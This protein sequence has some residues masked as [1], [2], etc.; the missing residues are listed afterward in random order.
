MEHKTLDPDRTSIHP[1]PPAYGTTGGFYPPQNIQQPIEQVQL[2]G[3]QPS[4]VNEPYRVD[5]T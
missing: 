5:G 3:Q 2:R 4:R 1:P